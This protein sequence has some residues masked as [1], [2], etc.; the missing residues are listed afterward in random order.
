MSPN[1]ANTPYFLNF[2]KYLHGLPNFPLHWPVKRL[3]FILGYS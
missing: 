3:K 1:S 2:C